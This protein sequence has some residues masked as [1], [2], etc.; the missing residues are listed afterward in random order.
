[1][2]FPIHDLLDLDKC[3]AWLRRHFHPE[4]LK[5]P[6]CQ[7][8]LDNARRFRRTQQSQVQTYRC[9]RCDGV[10]N[11][12]TDTIFEQTRLDPA[13][14]IQLLRGVFHGTPSTQLA[15]ELDLSYPTVLNWRHLIQQRAE[16]CLPDQP[17]PDDEVEADETF[18]TA[19]EKGGKHPDPDDPP[20][21]R[22]HSQRGRGTFAGDQPPILGAVGRDSG[23][24]RVQVIPDTSQETLKRPLQRWTKA[25]T[26]LY[27]D[28]WQGYHDLD[29]PHQQ[30][31]HNQGEYVR[32]QNESGDHQVHTNTIEGIWTG[33]RIMLD[34]FRGVSK[35]HLSGYVAIYGCLVN[36]ADVSVDL[37][38]AIVS[39]HT[40]FT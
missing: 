21:T 25:H 28:A 37:I 19:G 33:L 32:D 9:N 7:A 39:L 10:Y 27:T 29:R 17:L 34:R 40:T 23:Q 8:S 38:H 15:A 18:Q 35:H 24:V 6:H 4:G 14:V 11:I 22:A 5:C 31:N 1:M 16:V 30:V 13:Q 3:R 26:R 2:N 12:Y 20:R 36:A